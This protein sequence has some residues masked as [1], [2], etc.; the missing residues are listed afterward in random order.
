[1]NPSK[2]SIIAFA[3]IAMTTSSV[4]AANL[5]DLSSGTAQYNGGA[6]NTG[7][8]T[9]TVPTPIP[10]QTLASGFTFNI[11][12]TPTT[13]DLSGTVLLGEL[14]GTANGW[15]M[16]LYNGQLF[17]STK[18]NSSDQYYPSSLNDL[19]LIDGTGHGE[20]AVT[21]SFGSLSAGVEYSAAVSWDQAGHLNLA[22][23]QGTAYG[24]LDSFT[25]TGAFGNWQGDRSFSVGQNPRTDGGGVGGS[26]GGLA[27]E[28]PG[29][30][31]PAPWDVED[32][33]TPN[34]EYLKSLNGSVANALYWNTA[35][36]LAV[37]V[38]E[39][40]TCALVAMGLSAS[41][42]RLRSRRK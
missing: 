1:M 30:N 18:Q 3:S 40:A 17:F 9:A 12:F 36:N 21:S 25:L 39:P 7:N 4:L 2:G 11:D 10:T 14:G 19:T 22:V 26:V 34:V 35:G 16:F 33:S 5:T 28:N 42:L 31:P 20:A 38:P 23:Q 29:D 24:V 15:G 41:L 13:T 8:A 27:G 32:D 6:I 37:A